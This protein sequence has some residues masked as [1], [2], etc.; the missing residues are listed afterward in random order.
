MKLLDRYVIRVFLA[1]FLVLVMGLPVIFIVT[2]ITDHLEKYL[3]RGLT[4]RA[5]ALSYVFEIPQYLYWSFPVAALI[6]TVF[7]IGNMTRHQE[8]VAAKA[9]GVSFYRILAPILVLATLLSGVALVLADLVPITNRRTA[10]L[11]GEHARATTFRSNFV[12][13]T[14]GGQTLSVRRLN[15]DD[16]QMFGVIV[17]TAGKGDAPAIHE[18]AESAVWS[19]KTGWR[20]ERGQLR[21]ISEGEHETLF[22]FSSLRYP[23]LEETPQELLA[24]PKEPDEMRYAE[25]SRAIRTVER[26]GGDTAEL[27]VERAQK[28][29]L[30]LAVLVIVLF[31]A[32]LATSNRRG[33]TAYGIGMSL[34]ITVVYLMLFRVGAAFGASGAIDPVLAAWSPNLIF[35]VAGGVFLSRVRT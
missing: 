32:P 3:N 16:R 2:H 6:G 24:E 26:S 35:L 5:V 29:S 25:I 33:G 11:R 20:L 7:T 8:V 10:E 14:E 9:G 31:G 17:E 21:F 23:A 12:F 18:M 28:L 22:S 27:K 1:S 30:P 13:Q 34:A 19:P 15:A 4:M